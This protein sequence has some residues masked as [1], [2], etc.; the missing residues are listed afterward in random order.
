MLRI[1]IR[2]ERENR[3]STLQKYAKSMQ[4]QNID[5]ET[6]AKIPPPQNLHFLPI[7]CNYEA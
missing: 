7:F 2:N 1:T 3:E 5:N 4:L 6:F